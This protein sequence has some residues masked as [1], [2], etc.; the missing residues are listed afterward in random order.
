M[1][2]PVQTIMQY[3]GQHGMVRPTDIEVIGPPRD[4]LTGGTLFVIQ[5]GSA[6]LVLLTHARRHRVAEFL[7][8]LAV[9][10]HRQP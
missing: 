5:S 9:R 8:A 10:L 7:S 1:A 2:K 3:I 4:Y 6:T